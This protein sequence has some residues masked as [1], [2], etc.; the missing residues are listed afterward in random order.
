M[1]VEC[2]PQACLAPGVT[3]A[4]LSG[5]GIFSQVPGQDLMPPEQAEYNV[6]K[7]FFND[8]AAASSFGG[9]QGTV[10]FNYL[11]IYSEDIQY[12]TAHVNAPAQVVQANGTT[13]TM[14]TA[15]DL[16]NL[17]SQKLLEISEPKQAP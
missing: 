5:F 11:Q 9:T 17:A 6:L 14:T 16:L 7:Q 8:T 2:I 1:P 4:N 13:V 10:P 12:A 3:Q 15:Q